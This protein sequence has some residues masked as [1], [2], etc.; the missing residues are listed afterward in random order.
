MSLLTYFFLGSR[1]V[2]TDDVTRGTI[3]LGDRVAGDDTRSSM[4]A[5]DSLRVVQLESE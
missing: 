2:R 5:R 1:G 4:K 3:L